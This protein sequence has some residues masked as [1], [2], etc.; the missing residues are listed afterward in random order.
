MG[1]LRFF[2]YRARPSSNRLR[3]LGATALIG[4]CCL[5]FGAGLAVAAPR[6]VGNFSIEV[7][8]GWKAVEEGNCVV[9]S[10][11]KDDCYIT[12]LEQD[13]FNG[14]LELLAWH[15]ANTTNGSD[16]RTLGEGKGVVFADRIARFWVGLLDEKYM[17][18]A[19]GHKCRGAG[20]IMK[21]LKLSA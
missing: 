20:P 13:C 12:V 10:S 3:Q 7:P 1:M 21:S 9:L 17:E 14:D 16:L 19:V 8:A 2:P 15:S 4:L 18:V 5:A 6:S 11:P